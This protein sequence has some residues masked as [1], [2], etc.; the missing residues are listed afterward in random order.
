MSETRY[1]D[2][3]TIDPAGPTD[4]AGLA[5]VVTERLEAE[6]TTLAAHLTAA[7]CWWLLLVGEYD[8]RAYEQW[9]CGSMTHWLNVHVGISPSTARQHVAVARKLAEL[10]KIRGAFSRGELS[11]SRVRAICRAAKVDDEQRWIDHDSQCL[12]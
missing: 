11:F 3:T 1:V 7:M 2:P 5:G 8:R 4:P 6:I 10:P 9:E 12:K